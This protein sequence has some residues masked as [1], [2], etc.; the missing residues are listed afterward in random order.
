MMPT[1][2]VSAATISAATI[3]AAAAA[4]A[5]VLGIATP[6]AAQEWPTRPVTMVIPFAPGGALDVVARIVAPRLSEILGKPVVIENVGGAGGMTG[7]SRVAKAAPDGYQFVFGGAS[8]HAINQTLYKTPLYNAATD[9]AP[10][11]LVIE[12][13]LLLV[14]RNELPASSLAEFIAYARANQSRMQYGSSGA[15]AVPHLACSLLNAKVGIDVTHVPYRGTAPVTQDMLAGR[16]DYMCPLSAS[17]TGLIEGRQVK[18]LAVL[19]QERSPVL[20]AIAS[21]REQGFDDFDTSTWNAFFLPKGTPAPIVQKL[22]TA[23][24]ALIDTPAVRERLKEIGVSVVAAERRSPGYLQTF[25]ESEIE[26]WAAPIKAAGVQ[27]E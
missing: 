4:L 16:I 3:S 5:F 23:A 17:A 25:V 1:V 6:A 2:T 20:P 8:T 22:N 26:K 11:A 10:V 19:A 14:V 13:P 18:A 7:A 21:M 15:G 27:G 12:Q 9:F 24:A